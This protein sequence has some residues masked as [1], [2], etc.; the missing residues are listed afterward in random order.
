LATSLIE[1]PR[2]KGQC[3]KCK[4]EPSCNAWWRKDV[5][6]STSL[7]V[8]LGFRSQ[9]KEVRERREYDDWADI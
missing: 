5:E 6:A 3:D 4:H 9:K 1:A 7:I 2:S 8:C